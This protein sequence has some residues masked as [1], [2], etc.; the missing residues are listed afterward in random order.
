MT[1]INSISHKIVSLFLLFLS[2]QLSMQAQTNFMDTIRRALKVKPT[3]ECRLDGRNSFLSGTKTPISGIKA[4][5]DF[6][7]KFYVGLGWLWIRDQRNNQNINV[8]YILGDTLQQQT[9]MHYLS[10]YAQYVF[11]KKGRWEFCIMPQIGFGNTFY[12]YSYKQKNASD[13]E[14]KKSKV[15]IYEPMLSGSYRLGKFCGVGADLGWRFALKSRAVVKDFLTSPIYSFHF[16]IY[17]W[18]IYKT[19]FRKKKK[20]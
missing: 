16:D 5:L 3:A 18:T 20:A 14:S 6:N 19:Y 1:K 15:L 8:R 2:L 13:F 4:G 12:N 17:W 7:S 10:L 9:R 11:Y